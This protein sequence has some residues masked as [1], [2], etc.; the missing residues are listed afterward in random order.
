MLVLRQARLAPRA[1]RAFSTSMVRAADKPPKSID[2]S[3]SALDCELETRDVGVQSQ[4]GSPT[5][6]EGSS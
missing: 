2:D 4:M 3:T 5:W 6:S 1:A